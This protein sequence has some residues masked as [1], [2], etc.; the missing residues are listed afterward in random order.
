MSDVVLYSALSV[1]M[2]G[3]AAGVLLALAAKKFA[4][5]RKRTRCVPE[6]GIS[7]G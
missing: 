1:T 4:A 2:M 7:Y 3:A 5:A 6:A